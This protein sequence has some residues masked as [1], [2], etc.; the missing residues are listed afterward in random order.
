DGR[1]DDA[2]RPRAPGEPSGGD[3]LAGR[4][5]DRCGGPRRPAGGG[6]RRDAVGD[7]RPAVVGHHPPGAARRRRG[8]LRRG[9][10]EHP[11]PRAPVGGH[12]DGDPH[13]VGVDQPRDPHR[14]PVAGADRRLP[15]GRPDAG[16]PALDAR[17][18]D[19]LGRGSADDRRARPGR[20]PARG[21]R[22]GRHHRCL[23]GRRHV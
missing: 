22:P 5:G 19:R 6:V 17:G 3:L 10:A 14:S 23:P 2:A 9:D 18:H 12:R 1:D 7:G 13:A 20:G 8:R 21:R 4:C 11:L 15:A 16:V